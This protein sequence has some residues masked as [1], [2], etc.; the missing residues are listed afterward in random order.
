M[1]DVEY[2]TIEKV[3]YDV[4]IFFPNKWNEDDG[5]PLYDV[6]PTTPNLPIQFWYNANDSLQFQFDNP[7]YV[8]P[9]IITDDPILTQVGDTY[10]IQVVGN[11][12]ETE[13]WY[14][15]INGASFN[16]TMDTIQTRNFTVSQTFNVVVQGTSG[17]EFSA[18][19]NVIVPWYQII[20]F[21][22]GEYDGLYQ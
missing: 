22:G 7:Y 19:I 11:N 4:G 1:N 15:S 20:D 3:W 18:S 6:W 5:E 2:D 10:S 17:N 8:A 9:S 14:Y 13:G 16:F 21:I 12:L